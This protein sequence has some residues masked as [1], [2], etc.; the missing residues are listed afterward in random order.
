MKKLDDIDIEVLR[1]LI[2]ASVAF[3]R[4]YSPNTATSKGFTK[5]A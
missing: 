4:E 5:H 3:M 2:E 1:E